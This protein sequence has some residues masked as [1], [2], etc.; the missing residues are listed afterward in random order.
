METHAEAVFHATTLWR[1]LNSSFLSSFFHISEVSCLKCESMLYEPS[2]RHMFCFSVLP[3][4]ATINC[5]SDLFIKLFEIS[6][7]V[8]YA[9][10]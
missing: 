5:L 3:N 10:C 4:L 7:V 8:K 2:I 6:N 9:D 1:L